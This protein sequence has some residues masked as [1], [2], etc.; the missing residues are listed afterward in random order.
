M[1]FTLQVPA[2]QNL[3][4]QNLGPQDLP[5]YCGVLSSPA[6]V[7]RLTSKCMHVGSFALWRT[8]ETDSCRLHSSTAPNVRESV[9]NI[10]HRYL[11]HGVLERAFWM[12][13]IF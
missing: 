5:A 9:G 8:R 6:L 13:H 1:C 11:A 7:L 2:V 4:V 12:L 10:L 3:F